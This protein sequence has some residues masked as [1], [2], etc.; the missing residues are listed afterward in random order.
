[1]TLEA[2]VKP[3][4]IDSEWR[5][6][7][8]KGEDI[9]YLEC[10][11]SSDGAPGVGGTFAATSLYGTDLLSE[12]AW[13]H[14]AATY[15]G[16]DLRLY[17]DGTQVASQTQ[18]GLIESSTNPL[19]LG[20]DEF[21]GQFFDGVMDEVR[22]YNRALSASEIQ[23]DMSLPVSMTIPPSRLAITNVSSGSFALRLNGMAGLTYRIQI[24][25]QLTAPVWQVLGSYTANSSGVFEVTNAP[26]VGSLQRFYR[27]VYP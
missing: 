8:Y 13:A 27:A 3:A 17:V 21:F 22:I 4:T 24:S 11:T 26:P 25:E 9:Y 19:H 15:D 16:A 20:G 6:I 1:M 18:T 23:A 10:T 7:I 12:G 14:L 2:W 5:D